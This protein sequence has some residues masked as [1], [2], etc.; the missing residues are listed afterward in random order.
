QGKVF[1]DAESIQKRAEAFMLLKCLDFPVETLKVKLFEKLA[2][3][4]ASLLVESKELKVS[5][6][7]ESS[8]LENAYD[9]A[10]QASHE[11]S[12]QEFVEII[13]A[14]KVIF[15]NSET[16][17]SKLAQD[18]VSKN[19]EVVNEQIKKHIH[20]EDLVPTLRI[21]WADVI[22]IDD[23]L[24][25]AY[26]QNFT[27]ESAHITVKDYIMSALRLLSLDISGTLTK[28]HVAQKGEME[29]INAL[30][31]A[32]EASKKALMQGSLDVL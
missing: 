9:S 16:E 26:L 23:V 20:S 32:L 5:S 15:P 18:Y 24:P 19:F 4:L 17:L 28:I 30:Q 31:V 11:A 7:G 21:I 25:E 3:F 22:L 10:S 29:G 12:I 8:D 27:L 14:Y 13:R 2:Q 6:L 1:S